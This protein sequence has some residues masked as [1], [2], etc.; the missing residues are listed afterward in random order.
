MREGENG[1]LTVDSYSDFM[2]IFAGTFWE[3]AHWYRK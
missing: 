3:P 1:W 2:F